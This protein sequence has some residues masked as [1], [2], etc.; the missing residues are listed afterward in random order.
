M[1]L[2]DPVVETTNVVNRFLDLAVNGKISVATSGKVEFCKEVAPLVEF[3]RKYD[4]T[5]LMP[6]FELCLLKLLDQTTVQP[7]QVFAIA[8]A[9]NMTYVCVKT[10]EKISSMWHQANDSLVTPEKRP[11]HPLGHLVKGCPMDPGTVSLSMYGV[12]QRNHAWALHRAWALT[13]RTEPPVY[14][15]HPH[16]ASRN[17]SE[18]VEGFRIALESISSANT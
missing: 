12:I 14:P 10:L 13:V 2:C 6:Q 5:R 1:Q 7:M 15:G 17:L 18:V 8:S 4:C 3:L 11:D 9:A 16:H